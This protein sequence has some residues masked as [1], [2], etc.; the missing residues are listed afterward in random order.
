MVTRQLSLMRRL[1]RPPRKPDHV[2]RARAAWPILARLAGKGRTITY[3]R[4]STLLGLH[5]RSAGWFLGVIQ[6]YCLAHGLPPLNALAVNAETGLPGGG[7]VATGR[8]PKS[9]KKAVAS[10]S[11][12][13]WPKKAPF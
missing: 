10:V 11:G 5:H 1:R 7:Y 12:Y 2:A 6:Q 4:I 13:T 8:G 9:H 3:G